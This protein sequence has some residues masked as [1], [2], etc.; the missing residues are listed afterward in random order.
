MQ[1]VNLYSQYLYKDNVNIL[2]DLDGL[3]NSF[4]SFSYIRPISLFTHGVILL[5]FLQWYHI[6]DKPLK[7]SSPN[8]QFIFPST[9]L[10]NEI[11]LIF[12]RTQHDNFHL[13][14]SEDTNR[15]S[16]IQVDFLSSSLP[17][18]RQDTVWSC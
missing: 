6:L 12:R 1:R 4:P 15:T 13:S 10:G 8:S 16:K 9:L 3:Q 5:A 17:I 14:S 2:N 18:V 7:D 11:F